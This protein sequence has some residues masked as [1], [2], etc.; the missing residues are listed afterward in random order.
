MAVTKPKGVTHGTFN[1]NPGNI[2]GYHKGGSKTD[3]TKWLDKQ[4]IKYSQGSQAS[5]GGYFIHFESD[6]DG[7]KAADNF[8]NVTKTWA[9]YENK[10]GSSMTVEDALSKYS[11]GGYDKKFLKGL[12]AKGIDMTA[13]LDSLSD[14]DLAMMSHTQMQTEDPNQYAALQTQGLISKSGVSSYKTNPPVGVSAASKN[15]N[16]PT[17]AQSNASSTGQSPR[18]AA[19][20]EGARL[21]KLKNDFETSK[22][23][24]TVPSEDKKKEILLAVTKIGKE[25]NDEMNESSSVM[26]DD[27][28]LRGE[29]L[30][31]ISTELGLDDLDQSDIEALG[32]ARGIIEHVTN[33]ANEELGQTIGG[34]KGLFEIESPIENVFEDSANLLDTNLG[35]L[36]IAP[37]GRASQVLLESYNEDFYDNGE[38]LEKGGAD[39]TIDDLVNQDEDLLNLKVSEGL[40][41]EE[42]ILKIEEQRKKQ[43]EESEY[44]D[45]VKEGSATQEEQD[46]AVTGHETR[47]ADAISEY[48]PEEV[49][50]EDT[51]EEDAA[52]ELKDKRTRQMAMAEKALTGLKAAAGLTSLSKALQEPD[53]KTPQVSNLM[54]EALG[55]QKKLSTMGLNAA[56]KASAMQG[57]NEAYSGA[58]KNVLGASGGQRGSFLANQGVADANRVKGLLQLS[59]QDAA[60]RRQNVGQYNQLASSVGQM[61]LSA[62]MSAEQM[63]QQAIA[64][65]KQMLGGIGTNLL[66][67][68]IS[69]ATYYLNPN[70]EHMDEMMKQYMES[71]T[72]NNGYTPPTGTDV[73]GMN[74]P[75]KTDKERKVEAD[76]LAAKAKANGQ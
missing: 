51:I 46:A 73:I 33:I 52:T 45:K 58:I 9:A 76:A 67:D 35:M 38:R 20:E 13:S 40:T 25:L 75:S 27:D 44:V 66:S 11:N 43:K 41:S 71:T 31:R 69:D 54:L 47:L 74:D 21:V 36:G 19:Q 10:D 59:A 1:K 63:K 60:I 18:S 2:K 30:K 24:K 7:L 39:R 62:D 53:V 61:Q 55:K 29:F 16:V 14:D 8:W 68:A 37:E 26:F 5:D 57:I 6:E 32:E 70:R 34:K 28:A 56:E 23:I 17:Q 49:V 72:G 3:F 48:T 65:N 22:T 64:Q 42:A 15:T 4:G 12:E 50:V